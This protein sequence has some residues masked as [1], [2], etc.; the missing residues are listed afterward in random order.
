M[1]ELA[2]LGAQH[3]VLPGC[4]LGCSRLIGLF[5]W[6]FCEWQQVLLQGGQSGTQGRS[7]ETVV[8]HFHEATR[9]DVLEEALDE[10]LHG[11]GTGFEMPGI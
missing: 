2:A 11:E 1:H 8:A 10:L 9:Q 7:E 3:V 4:R 6:W 5:C